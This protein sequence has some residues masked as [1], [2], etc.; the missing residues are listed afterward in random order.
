MSKH[1]RKIAGEWTMIPITEDFSDLLSN[2]FRL[3]KWQNPS[4]SIYTTRAS[5]RRR[6]C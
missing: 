1:T 2:T 3:K 6:N 5:D 4:G